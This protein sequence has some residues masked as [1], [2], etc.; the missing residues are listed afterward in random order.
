[1]KRIACIHTVYSVI[2]DFTAQLREA[3]GEDVKI[4]TL[5]DD[6]LATDPADTGKFSAINHNRLRLDMQAQALTGADII[7]VSCSTLSPSVRLLR[8]EFNVPVVAIDDAMVREAVRKGTK[9]GLLATAN[10]TVKPSHSALLAAAKAAGK[11]VDVQII[12]DEDAIRALKSGDKAKH[13]RMVLEMAGQFADRD[14]I[15]LAQASIAHMERAVREAT[16]I[17]TLSSPARCIAEIKGILEA[18][19]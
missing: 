12:C 13:D 9:I 19:A 1:M 4:H 16:G 15:V 11:D 7:V 2:A 6:F 3:V 14:V 18:I 8:P 17:P 5:Y 10:S